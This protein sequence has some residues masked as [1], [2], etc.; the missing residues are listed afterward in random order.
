[1]GAALDE[2]A[3]GARRVV[4]DLSAVPLIDS[5]GLGVLVLA[6]KRLPSDRPPLVVCRRRVLEVFLL[7]G[8]DRVFVL[9]DTA[10]EPLAAATLGLA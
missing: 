6:S 7:T 10:E 4:I 8:R 9:C 5:T 1:M 3:P 2:A